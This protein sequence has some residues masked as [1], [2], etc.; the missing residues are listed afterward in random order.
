[1]VKVPTKALARPEE[2]CL[3]SLLGMK[4]Q[5]LQEP[6]YLATPADVVTS[7]QSCDHSHGIHMDQ[8]ILFPNAAG[9]VKKDNK[10]ISVTLVKMRYDI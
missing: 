7:D 5:G 10:L 9:I 2:A 1:M 3:L 8:V 4:D 6:S